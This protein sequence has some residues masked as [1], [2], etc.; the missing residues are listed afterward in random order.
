MFYIFGFFTCIKMYFT[1]INKLKLMFK[2]TLR[3]KSHIL[4]DVPTIQQQE[5]VLKHSNEFVKRIIYLAEMPLD[6]T[7]V[8]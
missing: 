6:V 2:T 3:F 5:M 4:F 7:K 8:D 1:T